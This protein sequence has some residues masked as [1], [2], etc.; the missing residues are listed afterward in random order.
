MEFRDVVSK[1]ESVDVVS[2]E[3]RDKIKEQ[4]AA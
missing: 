3:N 1:V 4:A 2:T